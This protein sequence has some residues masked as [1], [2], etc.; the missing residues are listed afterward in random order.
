[1]S[2]G[3]LFSSMSRKSTERKSVSSEYEQ[4]TF[5]N[6]SAVS[7]HL[8]CP[9]CQEAFVNPQR[10]PCGHS[11]CKLYQAIP[12]IHMLIHT[13]SSPFPLTI[14]T[15]HTRV[16]CLFISSVSIVFPLV[17]IVG[18]LKCLEPWLANN[19]VCPVDR[20]PVPKGSLHHDFIIES[21]IGDYTVACPWRALG[22]DFIGPLHL[23]ESHKKRCV[24]NPRSMPPALRDHTTA[25]LNKWRQEAET[26][27][28]NATKSTQP[29][30]SSLHSSGDSTIGV[31]SPTGLQPIASAVVLSASEAVQSDDVEALPPT[32]PPN[33][34]FRLYQ[35]SDNGSREL[36]CNFLQT[37][38][39]DSA[40]LPKKRRGARRGTSSR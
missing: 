24:M 32:P 3:P 39:L 33:L 30:T 21:I 13:P 26:S 1:M 12:V 17:R 36:L 23:L 40:P 28:M 6:P 15:N 34:L 9:I 10:A 14:F 11:F 7:P 20:K 4:R 37:S 27:T 29:V 16:G 38:S 22:C 8:F 19:P 35:N 25:L 18:T 5:V 2:V 31:D